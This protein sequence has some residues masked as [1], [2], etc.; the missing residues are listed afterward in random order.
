MT[1]ADQGG[2]GAAFEAAMVYLASKGLYLWRM[3]ELVKGE[4]REG[5]GFASRGHSTQTVWP[6][7]AEAVMMTLDDIQAKHHDEAD[8]HRKIGMVEHQEAEQAAALL[9]RLSAHSAA[10]SEV[11]D[12]A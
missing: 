1:V 10:S 5:W 9:A 6:T 7:I 8:R 2:Y 12:R 11:D 4:S 3:D